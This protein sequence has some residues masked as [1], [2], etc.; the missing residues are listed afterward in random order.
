[1]SDPATAE[2]DDAA[3]NATPDELRQLIARANLSQRAAARALQLSEREF[4]RM[5]AGSRPI[6]TVVVLALRA[7]AAAAQ[8][9]NK[10]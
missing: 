9:D 1:M 4:M 3:A 6:T 5:C 8:G 2:A 10:C 7:L